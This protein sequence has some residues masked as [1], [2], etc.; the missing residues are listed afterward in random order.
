MI[1]HVI[2]EGYLVRTWE[3]RGDRF[4]RLAC[5]QAQ[6]DSNLIHSDY[7]T[8][9]LTPELNFHLEFPRGTRLLVTGKIWGRDILE[10]LGKVIQKAKIPVDLPAALENLIL[11]RPTVQILASQ[12]EILNGANGRAPRRP[13][14][15]AG[16]KIGA[17][18][19]KQNGQL[20]DPAIVKPEEGKRR[21]QISDEM[22][23][24]VRP[25]VDLAN[26]LLTS[27]G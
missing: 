19:G 3:F 17:G 2:F 6:E 8:V 15:A 27:E 5:H 12:V 22:A 10:P 14:S 20:A 7:I 13:E 26:I 24:Q 11:P 21:P 4:L 16:R 23:D 1:N 9:Q 25:G 18:V